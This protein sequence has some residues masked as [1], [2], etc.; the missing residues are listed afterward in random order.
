MPI[1]SVLDDHLQSR[2]KPGQC[3]AVR[4]SGM[5]AMFVTKMGPPTFEGRLDNEAEARPSTNRS[6]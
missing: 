4:K 3:Q 2:R 6:R 1:A 5:V